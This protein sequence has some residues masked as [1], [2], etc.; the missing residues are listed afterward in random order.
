M[1]LS[2]QTALFVDPGSPSGCSPKCILCLG[3]WLVNTSAGCFIQLY[4]AISSFKAGGR[5]YGL[6]NPLC[7]LQL[8]RSGLHGPSSTVA[9]LGMSGWLALP[10]PGLAP[11]Q[12]HQASLGA[13]TLPLR[14]AAPKRVLSPSLRPATGATSRWSGLVRRC[15]PTF[16]VPKV[17][18]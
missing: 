7:T 8:F 11:G 3:F 12:K 5:P 18:R 15:M 14:G 4:E 17:S 1:L 16:Y 6:R 13:L 10:Q 2:T 9:T